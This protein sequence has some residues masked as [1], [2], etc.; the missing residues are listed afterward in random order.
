VDTID[1]WGWWLIAALLLA[2]VEVLTTLLIFGMLAVGAGAAAL[3]GYLGLDIIGQSMVFTVISLT[4]LV[5]VRPIARRHLRMPAE[6]RTGVAALIGRPAVVVERVDATGGRVKLE[7][8][9]WSAR[10]YVQ[11]QVLEPGVT[12]D[13]VEIKGATALVYGPES[14]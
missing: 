13:V 9:I 11:T 14:P 7:G 6:T 8:E 12:V 1:A 5:L 10:S 4:M 3:G 2:L